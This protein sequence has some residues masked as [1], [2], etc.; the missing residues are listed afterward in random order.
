M[1]EKITLGPSWSILGCEHTVIVSQ[2]NRVCHNGGTSITGRN[3]VVRGGLGRDE[4]QIDRQDP[5]SDAIELLLCRRAS[6]K[7]ICTRGI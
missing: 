1:E 7:S 6:T 4:G 2:V 5:L 3:A